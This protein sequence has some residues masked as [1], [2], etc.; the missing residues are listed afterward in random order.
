MTTPIVLPSWAEKVFL[1]EG[2]VEYSGQQFSYAVLDRKL[3]P[4]LPCFMGFNPDTGFLF[5]SD[6]VP[7]KSRPIVLRHELREVL[8]L[9][10]E[11]DRCVRSLQSE[12]EEVPE[13]TRPDYLFWRLMFFARLVTYYIR[14]SHPDPT[15][16]PR[17]KASLA[18]LADALQ[19]EIRYRYQLYE[20]ASG[21][22]HMLTGPENISPPF[23]SKEAGIKFA[24]DFLTQ[25]A[26]GQSWMYNEMARIKAEMTAAA[27]LQRRDERGR[28]A[29]GPEMWSSMVHRE[30]TM[31]QIWADLRSGQQQTVYYLEMSAGREVSFPLYCDFA[32]R[33]GEPLRKGLRSEWEQIV[34]EPVTLRTMEE[35]GIALEPLF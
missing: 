5:V 4:D 34:A 1:E 15:F 13:A 35:L 17:I 27:R 32:Q 6:E 25:H 16:L 10:G 20:C 18:F 14:R 12:L 28:F 30:H 26:K 8:D 9:V 21:H 24:D 2:S 33:K 31:P 7:E 23:W 19:Y 22:Y 11:D 3:Q 29:A